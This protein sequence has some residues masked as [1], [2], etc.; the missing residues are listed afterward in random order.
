MVAGELAWSLYP[1]I[2]IVLSIRSNG[3]RRFRSALELFFPPDQVRPICSKPVRKPLGVY[4]HC[5]D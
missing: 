3:Q 5:K 1:L 2:I 4:G